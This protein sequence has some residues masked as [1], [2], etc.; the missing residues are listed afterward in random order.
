V[1]E[2]V[3][4]IDLVKEQIKVAA[5]EELS[6]RQ[7]TTIGENRHPTERSVHMEGVKAP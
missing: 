6:F 4:G 7:S 3:T 1:T 5:G 2:L